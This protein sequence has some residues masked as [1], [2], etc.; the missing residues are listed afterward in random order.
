MGLGKRLAFNTAL[1]TASSLVMQCIAMAWQVWLAGRIGAAGIGLFQLVMSVGFL[2]LTVAVSGI[3]FGVTRLLSEE[4]GRGRG[5]SVDGAVARACAYAGF[6]GAASL[7]LLWFFA[8]PI[9]FLWIGDARTVGP[10]RI[11]ALA[12]PAAGLSSVLAGYF[13]AVGRVWKTAAEQF[14]EQLLRI[15]LVVL[16]LGRVPAGDLEQSCAAVV[17]AGAA[18]DW[19]GFL[20][21][22]LLFALDRRRYR[23]DTLR[24]ERLT[25]RMLSIAFPLALSAYARSA[26]NTFRQ[27]LVPRGLRLSGLSAD[28]ALSGYGV[29]NGMAFPVLVFPTC[30]PAALAELL[31]PALTAAQVSGR[32]EYIRRSVRTL[33]T[34]TFLLSLGAAA[35]FF[36]GADMLGGLI[37]HAPS[38][39]RYIR[40]LAPL[41][42]FLYTDIVTDGCLKGLGQ[43]MRSMTYNIAEAALGLAL[44]W[45][46]LPRWALGGY[47]FVL[48][49]CEVFNFSLSLRRLRQIVREE[50]S[51]GLSPP[52]GGRAFSA[53]RRAPGPPDGP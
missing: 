43:M 12:L 45:A 17:M 8:E 34:R 21:L 25:P 35:F 53:G 32:T 50:E 14:A 1:L 30:L 26:L 38:A 6:F 48:Y 24:G 7:L 5:G 9:G 47:V 13:T 33:L 19:A 44:V 28:A 36:A 11:L 4:L 39:A 22:F 18:A 29:I 46:L 15:G 2:F 20:L 41:V 27:L 16:L 52:G 3:R 23:E 31:V 10:L 40:I 51:A 42:P 37:Y 49:V